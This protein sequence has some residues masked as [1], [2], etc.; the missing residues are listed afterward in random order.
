VQC[1]F[2]VTASA[3]SSGVPTDAASNH[4]PHVSHGTPQYDHNGES[5]SLSG[6]TSLPALNLTDLELLHNYTTSTAFTLHTDPA[7]KVLWRINVAQLGFQNDFVMRG[8]LA[9]S[10]LHLARFRPERRD[11]Y[12][13]QALTQHQAGLR[14]TTGLLASI[15]KENC[16]AVGNLSSSLWYNG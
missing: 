12:M 6:D 5:S 7:L 14:M 16:S 11:F 2:L 9:L 13:S 15:T 4:S 3:S 1:D 8:I 10:A